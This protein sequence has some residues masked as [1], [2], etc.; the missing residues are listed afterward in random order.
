MITI[1]KKDF[2]TASETQVDITL[3]CLEGESE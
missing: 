1:N 2:I 3:L